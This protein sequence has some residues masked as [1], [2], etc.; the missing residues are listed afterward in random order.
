VRA[1]VEKGHAERI[2]HGIDILSETDASALMDD[3]AKRGVMVEICLS[4]NDQI[5]EVGGT[6]HPLSEYLKHNVPVALATDDQGVSRSS[7]AG[8][9]L[10]AATDQKLKYR[11]L[12]LMARTSLEHSFL[13][14]A[15]LWTSVAEA[16]TVAA[17][18]ATA[19]MGVGDPANAE[20][21]KVLNSSEKAT[22]QWELERRFRDFESRQ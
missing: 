4:S 14:G 15:S 2:G 11:Q 8:E 9:Y 21:L 5:L 3:M 17:C 6:K 19:T 7:L 22:I 10:R 12:K 18:A 13:P 1:A 20:C 16:K